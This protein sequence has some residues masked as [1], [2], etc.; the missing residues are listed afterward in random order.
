MKALFCV[1]CAVLKLRV[2][3]F[4]KQSEIHSFLS[5]GVGKQKQATKN[6]QETLFASRNTQIIQNKQK[7]KQKQS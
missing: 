4:W 6:W 7:Q 2:F 3:K 1:P 5:L